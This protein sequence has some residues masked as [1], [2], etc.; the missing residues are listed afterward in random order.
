MKRFPSLVLAAAALAGLAAC[1]STTDVGV[2]TSEA[3]VAGC[4]KV[5]DVSVEEQTTPQQARVELSDAARHQGANY[6]LVASD[7]AR[8]G[9]AYRCEN[10]KTTASR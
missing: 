1:A 5:G 3:L 7:D 6:V 10:N 4:Q 9:A 2:T 8:T